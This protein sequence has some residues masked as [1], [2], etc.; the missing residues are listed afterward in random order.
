MTEDY[1]WYTCLTCGQV[2]EY[3]DEALNHTCGTVLFTEN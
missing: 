1:G 2:F 3:E